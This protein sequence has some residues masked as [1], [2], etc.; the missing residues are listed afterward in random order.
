[1]SFFLVQLPLENVSKSLTKEISLIEGLQNIN[2]TMSNQLH[3]RSIDIGDLE[4]RILQVYSDGTIIHVT[5]VN[6]DLFIGVSY[7]DKYYG[8]TSDT[9]SIMWYPSQDI[10]AQ[11]Y[12]GNLDIFFVSFTQSV[13]E[14]L[15][16]LLG[17]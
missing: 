16:Y 5:L 6:Q 13:N 15:V 3:Q 4:I 1:M 9:P 14:L 10:P 11:Y 7:F 12:V 2:A 8:D 17:V